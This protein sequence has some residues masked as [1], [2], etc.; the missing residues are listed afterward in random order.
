MR[1]CACYIGLVLLIWRPIPYS[2]MYELFCYTDV[3]V[4]LFLRNRFAA[5]PMKLIHVL[6]II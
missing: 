1:Q 3:S 2:E 5:W 6:F 4:S